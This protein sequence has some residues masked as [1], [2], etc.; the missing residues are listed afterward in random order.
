M[1]ILHQDISQ[2]NTMREPACGQLIGYGEGEMDVRMEHHDLRSEYI[3][4]YVNADLNHWK[5]TN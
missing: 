4:F 1:V 3:W 2:V 5:E